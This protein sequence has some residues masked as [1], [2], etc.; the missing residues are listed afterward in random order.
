MHDQN[1]WYKELE[2]A[3]SIAYEAG[4]IMR[5]YFDIDQEAEWK[6]DGTPVTVAD[7]AINRIVIER[8]EEAFPEDGVIGEEESNTEYG[9]GRKW[10]CDPIDGTKAYTWGVPTAMFSLGLVIDGVPMVG[11]TYNP[12]I[13]RLYV[14]AK[15]MGAYCNGKRMHVSQTSLEQG[16]VA[17]TANLE[18]LCGE[19]TLFGELIERGIRTASFSGGVCKCVLVASGHFEGYVEE[20]LSPYDIAASQVI[21]EEAGGKITDLSGNI[22]DYTKPFQGAIASNGLVHEELVGMVGRL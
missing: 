5:Q 6:K 20:M 4:A 2:V 13:D 18:K 21:V 22:P 3:K 7:T 19:N 14:A 12:F 9:M 8:I 11:V 17:L 15:G 10:F 16:T 1:P